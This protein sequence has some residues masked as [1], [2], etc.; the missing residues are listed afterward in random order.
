MRAHESLS[1]VL[2]HWT[3]L[4]FLVLKHLGLLQASPRNSEPLDKKCEGA[5]HIEEKIDRAV[6]EVVSKILI[7]EDTHRN[8]FVLTYV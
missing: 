8:A 7:S 5:E 1:F 6:E 2:K 4:V 3:W